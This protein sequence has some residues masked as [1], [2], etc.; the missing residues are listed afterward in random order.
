M[1]VALEALHDSGALRGNG[2]RLKRQGTVTVVAPVYPD[3]FGGNLSQLLKCLTAAKIAEELSRHSV[4]STAVCWIRP[5]SGRG[6]SLGR[7]LNLLDPQRRLH[8]FVEH[9]PESPAGTADRIHVYQGMADL[10]AQV[11]KLGTGTFDEQ[12][13]ALLK[14]AHLPGDSEPA[15]MFEMF[16][17]PWRGT[18]V[19]A[20]ARGFKAALEKSAN[21]AFDDFPASS[22]DSFSAE[23]AIDYHRQ[24]VVF[25][26]PLFVL[27]PWDCA[28]FAHAK[29]SMQ[30][31]FGQ[32]PLCWPTASATVI[33]KDSRRTLRK[34]GLSLEDL[35]AAGPGLLQKL[36]EEVSANQA[37]Q[38]LDSLELQLQ[39]SLSPLE[40][41]A[42]G[43][44]SFRKAREE[45]RGHI[46][47]QLRKIG[48]RFENAR[49]QKVETVERRI[50]RLCASLIPDGRTQEQGLSAIHFMLCYGM[51]LPGL[52]YENLGVESLEHRT[53]DLY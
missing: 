50:S 53:L 26:R 49:I 40:D 23:A 21:Q 37:G 35:L 51:A 6:H 14:T 11:E 5:F 30:E 3:L 32:T 27:D 2:K 28:A 45:C 38:K 12:T 9:A 7:T 42:M 25:P 20:R 52:L 29:S 24:C 10:V 43:N 19:D 18:V 8:R 13:L 22:S 39:E 47:F 15:R 48:N 1:D 34:Y 41:P 33:D 16:L 31:G 46:L 44:R 17:R 36:K 4:D